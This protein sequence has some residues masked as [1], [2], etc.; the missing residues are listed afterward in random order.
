MFEERAYQTAAA[1]WLA[2]RRRGI[3]QIP[4][5]GGKSRVAAMALDMV[6]K[7]K[8]R[9]EKVKI[10]W[11]APSV[12]TRN[13]GMDAINQF[14]LVAAQD[15]K[16]SCVYPGV[17]FSDRNILIVDECK[18]SMAPV[19]LNIINQCPNRWGLDATPF[20]GDEERDN[21]LL[22]LYDNQIHTVNRSVVGNKLSKA[23]VV[24]LPDTDAGLDVPIDTK[25]EKDVRWREKYFMG[26]AIGRAQQTLWTLQRRQPRPDQLI[27]AAEDT[28]KQLRQRLWGQ[29]AWQT[30]IDI[31]IVENRARNAAA[32][33]TA[34][35]HAS[36]SVLLLVNKIE[37][38]EALCGQIP[39]AVMCFSK[40]GK[41][42]RREAIEAFKSGT[43]KCLVATSLADEGMDIP[44][45]NVLIL[46]SGG[47]STA[48]TEQRTGRVL[49]V[50]PGKTHGLIYDFSDTW[51]SLAAKHSRRR[52]EIY[53]SLDY[54]IQGEL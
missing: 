9:S 31:G 21:A 27:A 2:S 53:R 44:I 19:W 8:I 16:V 38:G 13:Q 6:L 11:I 25:V 7:K 1:E 41:K 10:G 22:A 39:G 4:A 36:D 40:M 15:V 29:V 18:H 20:F 42:K 14:P 45:A 43:L 23:V 34:R 48:R 28:V 51:H 37:H 54:K 32:V 49:R 17:D 3:I 52:V 50:A 35:R 24:L 47:R 33:A 26:G 5:G 46:V 12:E 30:C